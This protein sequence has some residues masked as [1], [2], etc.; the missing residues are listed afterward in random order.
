MAH[1]GVLVLTGLGTALAIASSLVDARPILVWN[2]TASV[3]RGLYRIAPPTALQAGDLALLQPD[4]ASALIYAERGYLPLGLP[5]VKRVAALAGMRVCEQAGEVAINNRH[6]ADALPID[7]Q[8]RPM[9][10][11]SGCRAMRDGELFVLNAD[12]PASLDGRY[13]GPSPAS[14]VIGRAVPLWTG[15]QR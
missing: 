7:G 5:L 9:T 13:F 12:M 11:W 1:A 4:P 6:V 14:S 8:G 10:P 15:N 2:A 3:P